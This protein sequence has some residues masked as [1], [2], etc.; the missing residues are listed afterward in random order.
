MQFYVLHIVFCH[1]RVEKAPPK[2]LLRLFIRVSALRSGT[3]ATSPW[4]VNADLVKQYKLVSKFADFF[5]SPVKV[6]L[7]V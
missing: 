3:T 1:R 4:V 2:D 5:L 6:G 7:I